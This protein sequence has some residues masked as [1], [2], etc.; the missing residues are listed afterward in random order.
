MSTEDKEAKTEDP[1]LPLELNKSDSDMVIFCEPLF[2]STENLA[3]DVGIQ[4]DKTEFV[5]GLK[6]SSYF[7]GM[8]TGLIN[9]GFSVEDSVATIFNKMNIENNIKVSE[10][11]AN[12]SIEVSKHVSN[13]KENSEL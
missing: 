4:F 12:S 10:I 1:I 2:I 9:A 7:A 3:E 8:Y 11:S 5:R 6:D 13:A